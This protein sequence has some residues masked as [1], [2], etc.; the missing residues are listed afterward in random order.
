MK[1]YT[2]VSFGL[3][4][5]LATASLLQANTIVVLCLV[6]VIPLLQVLIDAIS[7]EVKGGYVRRTKLLH[8]PSGVSV[9]SALLASPAAAALNW[10]GL[11]GWV[12]AAKLILAAVASGL[13]HLLLDAL[14]PGGIY[15][16]GKRVR[17]LNVPYDNPELNYL[18]TSIGLGI[19][20][21]SV[22]TVYVRA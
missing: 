12:D 1:S 7:H 6:P 3:G 17:L 11:V 9:F 19:A 10:L 5:G 8:S 15:V 21:Y 16:K 2:H 4:A 18:I 13:S 22:F 14:N 20:A